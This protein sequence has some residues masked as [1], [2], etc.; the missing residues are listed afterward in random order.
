MKEAVSST[1]TPVLT[2]ANRRN[3]PEV[4][5]LQGISSSADIALVLLCA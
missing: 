4:A 2:T 3:S 5:I 1:E